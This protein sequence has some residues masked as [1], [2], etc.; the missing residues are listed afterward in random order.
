MPR[1]KV[2]VV[3]LRVNELSVINGIFLQ[4][5]GVLIFVIVNFIDNV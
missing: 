5:Q 1:R 4:E 3:R 2:R